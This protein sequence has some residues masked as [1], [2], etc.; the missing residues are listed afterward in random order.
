MSTNE[1]RLRFID[2]K[3]S[4]GAYLAGVKEL[5]SIININRCKN[6][7]TI[8]MVRTKQLMRELK[9]LVKEKGV[10]IKFSKAG[11][12]RYSVHGFR[13]FQDSV[14]ESDKDL[15]LIANSLFSI[16]SGTGMHE[17][18]GYVVNNILRSKNRKGPIEGISHV[19]LIDTG[20]GVHD[21]GIKWLQPIVRS[22]MDVDLAIEVKY[23]KTEFETKIK[24]L[25]P[26]IVKQHEGRWYMVAYDH[27][28][29]RNPKT[30][31][32]A[33]AKI[34]SV[35]FSNK[36]FYFDPNFSSDDYF[37]YSIGIWHSHINSP[38]KVRF[39]AL[40]SYLFNTLTQVPI[41]KTQK[42]ISRTQMIFQI[43]VYDTPELV[44]ILLKNGANLKVISPVSLIS[45]LKD[46]FKK[47]ADLYS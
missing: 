19:K 13:F 27:T 45:R 20:G 30:N 46:E 25:S 35:E 12:F 39:K 41:H 17:R 24:I 3:L 34:Q 32:F 33:L 9:D 28:S 37:N 38:I 29:T 15:L 2:E 11:G 44:T 43:E 5:T 14:T 8:G 22:I 21:P 31:V 42:I 26:Y 16:F 7:R 23:K 40:T 6:E 10:D 36:N 4:E 18:F 47:A 1:N